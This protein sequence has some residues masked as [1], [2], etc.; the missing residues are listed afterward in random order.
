M[1]ATETGIRVQFRNA[2]RPEEKCTLTPVFVFAY[3]KSR[4]HDDC[5]ARSVPE[6]EVT[7]ERAPGAAERIDERQEDSRAERDQ[8]ECL[9]S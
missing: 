2:K 1:Q 8:S 3:A 7:R 4:N 5:R 9:F 6:H